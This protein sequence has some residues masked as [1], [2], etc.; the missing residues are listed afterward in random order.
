MT[1]T[2]T[3]DADEVAA[4]TRLGLVELASA[5]RGVGKMH[6]SISRAVFGVMHRVLGRRALSVR[7]VHDAVAEATYTSICGVL[8]VSAVAADRLPDPSRPVSHSP[9]GAGVIAVLDGLI[10]DAL[11]DEGSPLAPAL[12]VRVAGAP[13]PHDPDRLDEAFP[14]ATG[15]LVVFLHGLMES[16]FAW[17]SDQRPTYG[18]RLEADIAATEVQIRYN[19]GR[20]ISANGADLS[21]TLEALVE[22]WPVPVT[23]ISLVGHSMGGLVIRSAC[24]HA[25]E[26]EAYWRHLVTETVS[27]GTPHL[28]A[29][30]AKGVHAAT[31][32][33]RA[34]PV[35]EPLG[36]LLGRRSA[37][38]RDLFHGSLTDDD[39]RDRD[40]DAWIQPGVADPPL[41]PTARHLFVTASVMRNPNHPLGRLIG[42]GLVLTPSGR[43]YNKSRTVGFRLD[44]GM[45]IGGA[46]HF[47]LLNNDDIYDWL[48]G[49]LRPRP[50]LTTGKP[51]VGALAP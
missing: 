33:L 44:H 15:H 16:E 26:S 4:L 12:S 5:T 9:R 13:V 8:E 35:T 25:T 39:W 49:H 42:D 36:N 23:R 10:G 31:T 7:D 38:V 19:S 37:G 40:P 28:G 20:H 45:H 51:E 11:A 21:A 6:R 46:N 1:T 2:P 48:V 27:L 22:L 50:A 17:R 14:H 34:T 29:P 47:T 24:H 18:S 3:P 32:A 30:L 41:L 43:G